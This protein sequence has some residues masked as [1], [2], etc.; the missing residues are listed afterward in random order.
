[1]VQL[2]K[3][4]FEKHRVTA[5]AEMRYDFQLDQKNFDVSPPATYLDSRESANFYSFYAQDEYQVLKNLILN[6]GLRYDQFSTFGGTV[7]PRAALIYHPWEPTTFKLI[8]GQ[9]FRAPNAY[10]EYYATQDNEQNPHLGPE[11]IRS[12]ELVCEQR[13]GQHW[14]ATASLFYNDIKDL[15]HYQ[16]DPATGLYYFANVDSVRAEGAEFEVAAKWASGL[17]AR[18]S[19]AYTY[20][21]DSATGQQLSNS[22]ENLGQLQLSAPLWRD[23]LFASM[24]LEAMSDRQTASGN[25]VGPVWLVNATLFSQKIAK[26]LEVSASIYNLFDWRYSDPVSPDFTQDSIQQDGRQFRVKLTYKF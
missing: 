12:Y 1:L 9:A 24:E 20:T 4:F 19:Y 21:E 11:T 18:A 23:K 14:S 3:T 2:S 25:N 8:Y 7:N 10:E 16:Q 13:V 5:G 15:I 17:R 22:P 6:A 26:G